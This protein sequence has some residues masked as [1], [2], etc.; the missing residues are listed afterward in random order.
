MGP[1]FII[2]AECDTAFMNT[3]F[4]LRNLQRNQS[5]L[6]R[7]GCNSS[8]LV[9]TYWHGWIMTWG[10]FYKVCSTTTLVFNFNGLKT[11]FI[12]DRLRIGA[13]V[14]H[15]DVIISQSLHP[16]T[17]SLSYLSTI[18]IDRL[19]PESH[20]GLHMWFY[21]VA[22]LVLLSGIYFALPGLSVYFSFTA[23]TWMVP[24]E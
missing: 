17:P 22:T 12:L 2:L 1:I 24:I 16:I 14:L 19:I 5:D 21:H 20:L 15:I 6:A 13:L 11:M 7:L 4:C 18:F 23:G 3:R 10:F 9:P 8:S